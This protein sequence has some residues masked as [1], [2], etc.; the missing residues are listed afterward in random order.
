[1]F[2]FILFF[3]MPPKAKAKVNDDSDKLVGDWTWSEESTC[4]IGSSPGVKGSAKIASFDMDD[5]IITRKSGAK[6]PKDAYDWLLLNDKV[7]PKIKELS[8]D[9]YKIV[10]FTNQAGIQKGH[11]KAS[12][13]KTK[14]QDIAL[15]LR[16]EMQVFVAAHE[17]EFRKPGSRMWECL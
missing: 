7:G 6:F 5:T 16:V 17:D 8:D 14:V 11:T 10:I 1:M 3:E 9:G 4:L 13:I 15:N 12:D 2:D